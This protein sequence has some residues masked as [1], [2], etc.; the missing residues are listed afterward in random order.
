MWK[1][2][3]QIFTQGIVE[4]IHARMDEQPDL[5]RRQL[6]REVCQWLD[7]RRP[8]GQWKEMS[9]RKALLTLARRGV[10]RLSASNTSPRRVVAP[11]LAAS[12]AALPL[13]DVA[14]ETLG[15]LEL[16]PVSAQEPEL[17]AVWREL[18]THHYLGGGPLCG[19]QVRYLLRSAQFGWLGGFAF[20]SSA[21]RVA[22]RDEW[23]GWSAQAQALQ[24]QQVVNNSRFLI[25]PHVKVPNLASKALSLALQR[26]PADWLARYGVAP[27]LVE[28]FVEKER[29][30]GT[31]Y[32]AANWQSIGLTCG[33]GRQDA[34]RTQR[35][36]HKE[37]FVYPLR[38]DFKAILCAVPTPPPGTRC[39]P[40]SRPQTTDWAEEEFGGVDLGDARLTQRLQSLARDFYA[41][42]QA[43]IPQACGSRAKIK[44]AYRFFDHPD[45]TI[46]TLLSGHYAATIER[47]QKELVVLSV[48]DTTSLNYSG[49]P[50]ATGLGPIGSKVDGPTGLLVHDTLAF[51]V[52][53]TPLGLV[54]VKCWAR[55]VE[56]FGKSA[57]RRGLPI[58]EKE[59]YKWMQSFTAT[60]LAQ[61]QSPDTMWV[62]V[63]DRE[64]DVYELFAL[65]QA[66]P[67]QTQLLVRAIQPRALADGSGS[68]VAHLDAM[69]SVGTQTLH[70]PRSHNKPA[71]TAQLS[72]RYAPLELKCPRGKKLP[73]VHLWAVSAI[74]EN[75]P[76]DTEA[77]NWLLLTTLPVT[78]FELAIEKLAWY[79]K[80]WGIEVYHRVIKS[81]CKIENRQLADANRI[82]ACLALDMVVAWRIFHLTKLGRETPDL[83]CTVFFD[84]TEWKALAVHIHQNPTPPAEPPTLRQAIHWVASMGGFLGRKSDGEP[85]TQTLWLGIQ[86]LDDISSMYRV[87]TAKK[88]VGS[89][90][91]VSG[92]RDSG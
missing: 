20:S 26:L 10:V 57:E 51:N 65:A 5:S 31:C 39:R 34:A 84:D 48:Q 35:V 25:L 22:A 47:A 1:S 27:V 88:P 18:M 50:A 29:Y 33:R 42:P 41:R 76:P 86:R 9:C 91:V 21:W 13:I 19:A 90:R 59:S 49:H 36:P 6:S 70:V 12:K 45:T 54:H 64:A 62:S 82:E 85:G 32:L 89:T 67:N 77:L 40:P 72:I 78:T 37:I 15:V 30:A 43:N 8:N 71:R 46:K 38:P 44:A 63:G 11:P 56:T 68:Y 28:T 74:E 61:Q 87:F 73:S 14:L 92:R 53:G 24:R 55:D 69:P 58:E 3:G 75:P 83:P 52:D 17:S 4:R 80:R 7:W 60:S 2:S 79:A 66:D 23:I 16:I 81:G